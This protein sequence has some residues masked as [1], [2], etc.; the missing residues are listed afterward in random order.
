MSKADSDLNLRGLDIEPRN[1]DFGLWS[2]DFS[3]CNSI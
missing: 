3:L 2:L 1:Q